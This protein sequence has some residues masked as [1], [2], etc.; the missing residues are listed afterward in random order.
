[1]MDI[2]LFAKTFYP[3]VGGMDIST[4]IMAQEMVRLGFSVTVVTGTT[5]NSNAELQEGYQIVRSD[6][7]TTLLRLA[8]EAGCVVIR[9]G[10]AATMGLAALLQQRPIICFHEMANPLPSPWSFF[11]NKPVQGLTALIRQYV[12]FKARFH[13]GVSYSVLEQKKVPSEMKTDVL[14]NP[15]PS[16]LWPKVPL[17]KEKR[18][19]DLLFVGRIRKDKGV[20][21]LADAL[22]QLA[23]QN[24]LPRVVFAGTGP[25]LHELKEHLEKL[26]SNTIEFWGEQQHEELG[27][28]YARS[29]WAIIPSIVIEAMGMVAAEALAHGTP[30]IVSDQAPLME[31]MGKGGVSYARLDSV[32]LA[33]TLKTVL[34]DDYPWQQVAELAW[35]ERDRFSIRAYRDTL[36]RW[37]DL[38]IFAP[39]F[40]KSTIL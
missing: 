3:N 25:E 30:I 28:L 7:F 29:R 31:V 17:S 22:E 27:Q 2:L 15:V 32:S 14:Y 21:I 40:S 13:V 18:D 33:N 26:K 19:I 5:L 9:G 8:G 12:F 1:M 20:F 6:S 39:K 35:Q 38:G 36:K 16:F 11:P 4:R 37:I 10:I 34:A 24:I 23:S